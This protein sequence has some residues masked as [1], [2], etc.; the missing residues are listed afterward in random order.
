MPLS[1]QTINAWASLTGRTVEP[2]EVEAIRA[3][4]G[5]LRSRDEEKE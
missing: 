3:I 4:D 2:W 1:Y 5:A